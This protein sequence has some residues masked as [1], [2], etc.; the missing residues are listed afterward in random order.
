MNLLIN[1]PPL[2]VLPTLAERIGL[3]EAIFLQQLHYWLQ[4]SD[5]WRDGRKW[6]YKSA[7]EWT[8]EFPFWSSR[9]IKRITT[10]L[11]NK[12][13]IVTGVYNKAGFDRTTWYSIDY[14]ALRLLSQSIGTDCP[15]GEGQLGTTIGTDC[16]NGKGQIVPTNT[17]EYTE[18]T[19]ENTQKNNTVSRADQETLDERFEKL[20]ALYPRKSRKKDAL[21]AY[22]RAI[23][24]GTTDDDI[25]RGIEAYNNQIKAEHTETKYI[26]QGGTWFNQER[27][28]DEYSAQSTS[29]LGDYSRKG[30]YSG[31]W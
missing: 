17:I 5:N 24:K 16:P 31:L 18:N 15:N 22:K 4:R 11:K 12:K 6:C 29:D 20:W 3:N 28:N 7:E 30:E 13:L 9:T 27:W 25:K 21:N 1:E 19:T 8:K 14:T 23:K 26:A 2:Q 10:N